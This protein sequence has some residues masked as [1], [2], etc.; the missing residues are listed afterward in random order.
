[1]TLLR[2]GGMIAAESSLDWDGDAATRLS[3]GQG[4]SKEPGAP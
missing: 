1:L 3:D 4:K 2:S